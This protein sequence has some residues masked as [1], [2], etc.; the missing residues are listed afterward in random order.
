MEEIT[1]YILN[2]LAIIEKELRLLRIMMGRTV[3]SLFA[4]GVGVLLVGVAIG[5]LAWTCFT[6]LASVYG[7][8]VAGLV[9]MALTLLGGGA[10]LWIGTKNL[11]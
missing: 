6:A 7:P 8:V 2:L 1:A 11:R 10:L 5:I 4:I 3:L 9:A